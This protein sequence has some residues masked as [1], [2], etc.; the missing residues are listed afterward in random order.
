[1]GIP[2]FFCNES[3]PDRGDTDVYYAYRVDP[4]GNVVS[5]D[6]SGINGVKGSYGAK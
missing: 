3:S 4:S 6:Y 2:I 1:M 5:I